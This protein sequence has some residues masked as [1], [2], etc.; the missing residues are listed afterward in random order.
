LSHFAALPSH[1]AQWQAAIE[2]QH[3][4]LRGP[5]DVGERVQIRQKAGEPMHESDLAT[6]LT[7]DDPLPMRQDGAAW[8]VPQQPLAG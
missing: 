8:D 4:R 1:N 6:D 2:W 3:F 5:R 7:I